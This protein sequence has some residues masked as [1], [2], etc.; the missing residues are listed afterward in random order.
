[1]KGKMLT[2]LL[3]AILSAPGISHGAEKKKKP[4]IG[5]SSGEASSVSA[6]VSVVSDNAGRSRGENPPAEHPNNFQAK[7]VGMAALPQK[8][9][10]FPPVLGS[11]SLPAGEKLFSYSFDS[12]GGVHLVTRAAKAGEPP[13]IYHVYYHNPSQAVKELEIIELPTL[14]PFNRMLPSPPPSFGIPDRKTP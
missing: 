10:E 5:R 12:H 14:S 11:I 3:I 7:P 4:P 6:V 2:L 1:M 9:E 8:G 13:E